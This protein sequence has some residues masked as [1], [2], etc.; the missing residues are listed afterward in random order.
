MFAANEPLEV[1]DCEWHNSKSKSYPF[2]LGDDF[3]QIDLK[4]KSDYAKQKSLKIKFLK[5]HSKNSKSDIERRRNICATAL[6]TLQN[7]AYLFPVLVLK[8]GYL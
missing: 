4:S 3:I 8:K 2:K 5:A 1:S 7:K 6:A